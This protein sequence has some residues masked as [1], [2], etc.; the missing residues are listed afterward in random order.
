MFNKFISIWITILILILIG[1]IMVYSSTIQK[2]RHFFFKQFIWILCCFIIFIQIKKLP[3]NFYINYFYFFYA[4]GI[5]LLIL[6]LFIGKRVHGSKSWLDFYYFSF[7]PSELYKI[8]FILSLAKLIFIDYKKNH[9]FII[10]LKIFFFIFL[11]I[12]LIYFQPD[13]GSILIYLLILFSLIY[14]RFLSNYL[15][16]FF[17]SFFI[18]FVL[19]IFQKI[20]QI[21]NITPKNNMIM[22]I[23]NIF[24]SIKFLIFFLLFLIILKIF[25]IIF[26]KNSKKFVIFLII[27]T[28][29]FF[30]S[31]YLA[32]LFIKKMKYYQIQRLI[33]FLNPFIDPLGYGYNSIQSLIA[34]GSGGLTGKGLFKG[35]QSRLGFLPEKRTDFIFSVICEELGFIGGFLILT[36]YF[37]LLFK[38]YN[39]IIR[40]ENNYMQFIG[41]GIFFMTFFEIII[42]IS[43]SLSL[44]PT[45]GL[46][47]PFISYGGSSLL[48]FTIAY[49][50]IYRILN[51]DL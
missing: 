1:L 38:L 22:L 28:I 51:D 16:F 36:L 3:I 24:T 7:Q 12:I 35:T 11:P 14:I 43:V 37:F 5:F 48:K 26:L 32:N 46:P 33:V 9:L 29:I 42:N 18:F 8:I 15:T 41:Y 13:F 50:M 31:N 47:L 49:S 23:I 19:F 44:I 2:E 4:I 21:Y 34:I 17:C 10:L 39:F 27:F 25:K 6:V 20:I 30:S 40:L 45:I